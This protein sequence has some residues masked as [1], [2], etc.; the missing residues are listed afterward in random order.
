MTFNS[1]SVILNGGSKV[2][3]D[4]NIPAALLEIDINDAIWQRAID[5]FNLKLD[6]RKSVAGKICGVD[7]DIL[8]LEAVK[9]TI[10]YLRI[11]AVVLSIVIKDNELSKIEGVKLILKGYLEMVGEEVSNLVIKNIVYDD[12]GKK[13]ELV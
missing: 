9:D 4:V 8:R 13:V 7:V 6:K 11:G 12:G 5:E 3:F 1:D 2:Y 10:D